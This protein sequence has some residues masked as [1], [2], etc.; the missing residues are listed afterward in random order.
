MQLNPFAIPTFL[1][2]LL[3]IGLVVFMVR[4]RATAVQRPLALMIMGISWWALFYTVELLS[5]HLNTMIFCSKLQY[6]GVVTIPI[7]WVMFAFRYAGK[8][9]PPRFELSALIPVLTLFSAWA[10]PAL[11][12]NWTDVQLVRLGELFFAEYTHGIGFWIHVAYTYAFLLWGTLGMFRAFFASRALFRGQVFVLTAAILLPWLGNAVYILGLSPVP[13]YDLTPVVFALSATLLVW[14]NYAFGLMDLVPVARDVVMDSVA[15]AVVVLDLD[16]RIVDANPVATALLEHS[17]SELMGKRLNDLYPQYEPVFAHYRTHIE[18]H[19]ELALELGGKKRIF[20]MRLSP[21]YDRHRVLSGRVVVLRD[22]TERKRLEATLAAQLNLFEQLLAVARATSAHP[23]LE[24]TLRNTL[25]IAVSMT[26]S[27]RGSI[28][29]VNRQGVV[30]HQI[31]ARGDL[32]AYAS[33]EI[34]NQ[35]LEAGF[36]GWLIRY[37]QVALLEDTAK[38]SRWLT[39]PDQ[40]YQVG[41]VLG[42]PIKYLD[43]LLGV[44]ILMHAEPHHYTPRDVEVMSAAVQQMALAVRNAQIYYEQQRMAERQMVLFE[45]LRSAQESLTMQQAS[46][47]MLRT[48]SQLTG[49]PLVMLMAQKDDTTWELELA[50]GRLMPPAHWQLKMTG[51]QGE[52]GRHCQFDMEGTLPDF[53][54]ARSFIAAPVRFGEDVAKGLLVVSDQPYAFSDDDRALIGPLVDVMALVLRNAELFEQ[55]QLNQRRLEALIQSTDDG[56]VMLSLDRRVLVVNQRTLDYLGLQDLTPA[57]WIGRSV[58]EVFRPLRH[59]SPQ[60][61][62]VLMQELRRVEKG[63]EAPATGE[64]EVNGRIL[65]WANLPVLDEQGEALGRLVILHDMTPIRQAERLREDLIHTMVHD[66]RNPLTAVRGSLQLLL[67]RKEGWNRAD[68]QLLDLAYQGSARMLDLVNA[69]LDVG[70]LESGRMPVHFR[71]ADLRTLV[72]DVLALQQPIAIQRQVQLVDALP[73]GLPPVKV[74]TD[75]IAR[76]FQNLVGNALKFTPAGGVVELKARKVEQAPLIEVRIRDTGPGIPPELKARLFGKFVTGNVEGRGSGLGL[77][78]C[79]L[80]LEAHGQ[81]ISVESEVGQGST[82][83]FTLPVAE[84]T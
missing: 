52:T 49:W 84:G 42:L 68:A 4:Q 61:V 25:D 15:D 66:L 73:D 62:R 14:G 78:F 1:S 81:T 36:A 79:K 40:P 16:G 26:R 56:I 31:L 67:G 57:A 43:E 50:E 51:L 8:P 69:I 72:A 41:S 5:T 20:D 54:E 80:A 83:I 32:P 28:L 63:D 13:Y 21:I 7:F 48:L 29:L 17:L 10:Y 19:E 75:L 9:L 76:V 70:R 55:V 53:P 65:A 18:A 46:R 33:R 3:G 35:V 12:W 58:E 6:L 44:L 47:L 60:A 38:D 11:R 27:E 37:G 64:Y 82:F 71:T 39:L 77:A 23:N 74:D 2:T 24:D 45:V 22:I 30:T 34:V 59:R